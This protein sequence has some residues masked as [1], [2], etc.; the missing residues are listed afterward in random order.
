MPWWLGKAYPSL[1]EY[2]QPDRPG[3]DLLDRLRRAGPARRSPDRRR[4]ASSPSSTPT[5]GS[6]RVVH[7]KSYIDVLG[8]ACSS[9]LACGE[10]LR[11][12][13]A[14][15]GRAR[16]GSGGAG[17]PRSLPGR[18]LAFVHGQAAESLEHRDD[19]SGERLWHGV[20]VR[21]RRRSA[22]AYRR[23][24]STRPMRS[25]Y[26]RM[27]APVTP[28]R[29]SSSKARRAS[30]ICPMHSNGRVVGQPEH[31]LE[32]D[33]VGGVVEQVA[34]TEGGAVRRGGE[35]RLV[36]EPHVGALGAAGGTRAWRRCTSGWRAPHRATRPAPG[37]SARRAPA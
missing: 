14:A 26:I 37:R 9:S 5:T 18:L 20:V 32:P 28:R 7:R 8:R 15:Y 6:A 17:P 13:G 30:S 36:A 22:R 33:L 31:L 10:L 3:A 27:A 4:R 35:E 19:P 2:P 12:V 16:L 1:F 23:S 11:A 24:A 34:V 21:A 25:S 29:R